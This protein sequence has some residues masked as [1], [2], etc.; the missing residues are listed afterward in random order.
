[1]GHAFFKI[2]ALL[3]C[4]CFAGGV[5]WSMCAI[6]VMR[7]QTHVVA[8]VGLIGFSAVTGVGSCIR[9]LI[10]SSPIIGPSRLDATA[11]HRHI[12]VHEK[13]PNL[14]TVACTEGSIVH[15]ATWDDSPCKVVI[16]ETQA[17]DEL[18][19]MAPIQG[20]DFQREYNQS[21]TVCALGFDSLGGCDVCVACM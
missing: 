12:D 13:R 18:N 15:I 5:V 7:N 9:Y 20:T 14:L 10:K 8:G 6:V 2:V 21:P 1:M 11:R 4:A 19:M 3:M 16:F 17:D